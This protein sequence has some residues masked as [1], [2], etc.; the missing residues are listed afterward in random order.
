MAIRT[1]LYWTGDGLR[2]MT[3][4]MISTILNRVIWNW[5]S[6][7][8]VTL[9][10][11]ASAGNLDEMT[12]TRY[13]AGAATVRKDRFATEA[14]TPD[15]ELV[16]NLTYDHVNQTVSTGTAYPADTNNI[17]YPV[18]LTAANHIRAMSRTDFIDTFIKPAVDL[19]TDSG[20]TNAQRAG[21]Y[22][23]LANL[24][25]VPSYLEEVSPNP[26]FLNTIA[27]TSKY[28]ADGI[29]EVQ[30]QPITVDTYK[31]YKYKNGTSAPAL[32]QRPMILDVDG[33]LHQ[34]SNSEF[35]T[36]VG[37]A[38]RHATSGDTLTG[39]RMNYEISTTSGNDISTII[40]TRL[41]GP[42]ADGYTQDSIVDAYYRT[43]EFP[44]G[45]ESVVT[46]YYFKLNLS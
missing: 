45:V 24:T 37:D 25:T 6:N 3:S 33:D 44:N 38:I 5:A 23:I 1:P 29:P 2:P 26:V 13:R 36:L 30:D 9:S 43:Q 10:Y 4:G 16:P 28:T 8:S 40:D 19:M 18:Y 39:Y 35:D 12:D 21:T 32:T 34:M 46:T 20:S 42:S 31:L 22:T 11:L 41:N 14:E 15:I 7:P 17:A 27:D